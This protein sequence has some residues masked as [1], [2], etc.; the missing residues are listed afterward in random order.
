MFYVINFLWFLALSAA[1]RGSSSGLKTNSV[2]RGQHPDQPFIRY[3][4]GCI[5]VSSPISG[6][7]PSN[8]SMLELFTCGCPRT[9][10]RSQQKLLYSIVASSRWV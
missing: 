2:G 9:E 3:V 5:T 8:Q 7:V 1:M 6:N 4:T 10:T